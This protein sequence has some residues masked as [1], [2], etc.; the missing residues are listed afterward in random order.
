MVRKKEKERPKFYD[1]ESF[2]R[3]HLETSRTHGRVWRIFG[4]ITAYL[5]SVQG[6]F[7]ALLGFPIVFGT[8]LAV[9]VGSYYGPIGFVAIMG[10]IIGG[11]GIFVEKKVGRSLQFGEY[12]VL[13]RML[14]Q[15]VAF[16]FALGLL[17]FLTRFRL[18]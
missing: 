2:H 4:R 1:V 6:L 5:D 18:F 17:L 10:S 13:K 7:W 11:L 16:L 9:T 3:I 14:L 12:N 15:A 8:V